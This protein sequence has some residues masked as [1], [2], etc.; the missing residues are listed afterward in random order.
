[1]FFVISGY[2]ISSLILRALPDASSTQ[3]NFSFRNFYVNRIHRIFPALAVVLLGCLILGWF[4]LLADEYK[5]L[6]KHIVA[7]AA[8]VEN[9]SLWSE[10]G[11]FDAASD[12]KPLLHL[13]SLG[14]EE[15][16]YLIWPVVLVLAIRLRLNVLALIIGIVVI[17]FVANVIAAEE[18]TVAAFYSPLTRMWELMAGGGLAY[19]HIRRSERV[20]RWQAYFLTLSPRLKSVDDLNNVKSS[21]GLLLIL[22]AIF[23]LDK[24]R[25]FPGWWALLPTIG[26]YLIIAGG[27]KAWINHHLLATRPFV[28]LGLI[29][30]PLYLWHWPLLAFARILQGG[31]PSIELRFSAILMA[32]VLSCL[33]YW[34]VEK[35]LRF[36]KHRLVTFSLVS[37]L[38]LVAGA[39]YNIFSRDGLEFRLKD[40][41]LQRA[42][43]NTTLTYHAQCR[44]DFK[45]AENSFCLRGNDDSP[46]TVALIGD[47][48]A[49]NLFAGLGHY[50]AQRGENLVHF[51][52]GG[53]IPFY[54][55]ERIIN[56]RPTESFAKLYGQ[57]LDYVSGNAEIKTVLL[58][59]KA[60][61][62][63][64]QGD[65][66]SYEYDPNATDAFDIYG[67][68]LAHTLEKL[69]A[70]GK[71]IV[72][73][74][75]APMMDFD[76][77]T[78]VQ[79]PSSLVPVRNL[80]G[81]PRAQYDKDMATYRRK[82]ERT[83]YAYPTVRHWDLAQHMCDEQYCWAIKDG[84]MLYGRDGHHLSMAASYWLADRFAPQ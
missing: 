59:N 37:T 5:H 47:S 20:E 55:V 53:G 31:T 35:R 44:R 42:K 6:G 60:V 8:F 77:G 58:M 32:F 7:G 29:S 57:I 4:V 84:Q 25:A 14:I 75:D 54:G 41:E 9:I 24:T 45:F 52:T 73:V 40:S 61:L 72:V 27:V 64:T 68:A 63:G 15:Q 16:F 51:G 69:L 83:L 13:W 3:S 10:A 36:E 17:S 82:I 19:L 76:P 38:V 1:M 22:A 39:G 70:A 12:V 71:D 26:A 80:C 81:I 33:T 23:L 28:F 49:M 2:L 46:P 66:L 79:R 74:I 62:A 56:G 18:R 48:H 50:Y 11:Y 30:Y 78:C 21:M 67:Q 65:L 34:I 43:F